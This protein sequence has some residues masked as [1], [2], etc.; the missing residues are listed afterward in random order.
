MGCCESSSLA[1]PILL[2]CSPETI[3]R[4]NR[5]LSH[6]ASNQLY[7]ADNW[8]VRSV[9]HP[10][11]PIPPKKLHNARQT[12]GFPEQ[13]RVLCL[14]GFFLKKKYCVVLAERGVY[15]NSMGGSGAL[16]YEDLHTC[17]LT[18]KVEPPY[19]WVSVL[20][21]DGKQFNI[22]VGASGVDVAQTEWFKHLWTTLC[23][24]QEPSDFLAYLELKQNSY[25]ESLYDMILIKPVSLWDSFRNT[26][27]DLA[28]PP[29]EALAVQLT[30]AL[31]G[32]LSTV[33]GVVTWFSGLGLSAC[34]SAIRAKK[35]NGE[36]LFKHG[37][38]QSAK[39][40]AA[41]LAT[42]GVAGP[43]QEDLLEQL[44]ERSRSG[45]SRGVALVSRW[46]V[47][48]CALF[49]ETSQVSLQNIYYD[50]QFL[51]SFSVDLVHTHGILDDKVPGLCAR[52]LVN[53]SSAFTK[54]ILE[55]W[56]DPS[57]RKMDPFRKDP[58]LREVAAQLKLLQMHKG[59]VWGCLIKDVLQRAMDEYVQ[60]LLPIS[61]E[62]LLRYVRREAVAQGRQMETRQT[63]SPA[64]EE[65]TVTATG[66]ATRFAKEVVVE[67]ATGLLCEGLNSV[68]PGLGSV[69]GLFL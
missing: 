16:S 43:Q 7:S 39:K 29:G 57:M 63:A 56:G 36:L 28:R 46:S 67:F 13:E 18:W 62:K 15:W 24:I 35:V 30:N 69:V 53:A 9:F 61:T 55:K 51:H 49:A 32:D 50:P 31:F 47:D 44:R 64:A 26:W 10:D 42:L 19:Y 40:R 12:P 33:D 54:K 27:C 21:A 2:Q 59:K 65:E 60:A 58:I 8:F 6:I 48:L 68:V 41:W 66:L 5:I 23:T 22:N 20:A 14:L 1:E 34:E 11:F 45:F 17:T 38:D 4:V 3:D 25:L 37:I 52:H